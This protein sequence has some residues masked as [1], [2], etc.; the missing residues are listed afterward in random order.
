MGELVLERLLVA[1]L[2]NTRAPQLVADEEEDEDT[3]GDERLADAPHD[4]LDAERGLRPGRRPAPGGASAP[5]GAARAA[6]APA[7]P[8]SAAAPTPAASAVV[9]VGLHSSTGVEDTEVGAAR[10]G[11]VAT[12]AGLLVLA[13]VGAVVVRAR[14]E[15]PTPDA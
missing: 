2:G 13:G 5:G 10:T 3:R 11:A 15:P 14:R 8:A 4:P 6:T 1:G 12:G 7:Q 9:N